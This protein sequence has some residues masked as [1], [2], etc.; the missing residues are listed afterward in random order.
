MALRLLEWESESNLAQQLEMDFIKSS[1]Q[2]YDLSPIITSI[3]LV[4]RLRL[5]EG[6]LLAQDLTAKT[7]SVKI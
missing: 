2:T 1:Q 5:R 3:G 4:R 7:D 6:Q